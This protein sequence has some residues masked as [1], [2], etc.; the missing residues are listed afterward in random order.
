MSDSKKP[1]VGW[2]GLGKMGGPMASNLLAAG[3][4]LI[5]Y[6]RTAGAAA[7]IVGRGASLAAS[8]AD[9]ATDCDIVISMISDDEALQRVTLETGGLFDNARPGLIYIDMSTVSPLISERVAQ[10]ALTK[11]IRYLRAPV[12]GSTATAQA[13]ALTI[14]V[15]G[16]QEAHQQCVPVFQA[17]G[18]KIYYLGDAE[19]SRYLKIAI[20]MMLGVTAGMLGEALALGERGGLDWQQM[21]EVINNSVIASPLLG[22]KHEMLA[23]RNFSPMFTATQ[24]AK[25]FDLALDAGRN[26]NVP[27]PIAAVSRQFFGAMIASGRG[28][29]DFFAYVTLLEELAGLRPADK[30]E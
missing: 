28:E 20:N 4:P 8:V 24:M 12:S 16:P 6:N 14:L 21:L 25:D 26:A 22:Y 30:Y 2:I 1:R 27:M 15:S 18:T 7:G 19:Q 17:I 29:L 5:V 3:F 9:L 11:G 10:A 13:A 23:T